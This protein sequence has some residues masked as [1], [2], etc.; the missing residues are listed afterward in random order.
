MKKIRI[1]K[2]I[3]ILPGWREG[4]PRKEYAETAKLNFKENY[5]RFLDPDTEV[6]QEE[7][8]DAVGPYVE[9]YH[10]S[11][12]VGVVFA[13]EALKGEEEGYDAIYIGCFAEPGIRAAREVCDTLVM[14]KPCV[15]LHVA[16]ML[17]D[18]FSIIICGHGHIK[19]KI[20]DIVKRYGLESRLASIRALEV[21][22]TG[23]N[24]SLLSQEERR[25][26]EEKALDEARRAIE[27]DGAEVI[28]AYAGSHKHLSE[29]LDVPVINANAVALKVTETLV[30]LGLTHSKRTYPK[31]R[32]THEYFLHT[33][34]VE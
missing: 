26:M 18:R 32:V 17:G 1:F 22:P 20:R 25:E 23:M 31:P 19:T 16:S 21:P 11:D 6:V 7:A 28:I 27:E 5:E 8:S 13:R 3:V 29:S 30:K 12:L 4:E 15:A 9:Q 33:Q 34:P 24:L 2:P 10:E 14:S